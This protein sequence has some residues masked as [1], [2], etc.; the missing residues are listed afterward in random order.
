MKFTCSR[1]ELYEALQSVTRAVSGR[2]TDLEL[3]IRRPVPALT[4]EQ[5]G[6]ITVPAKTLSEIVSALPPKAELTIEV[7]EKNT[8]V[9][10]CAKSRYKILGLSADEFPELPRVSQDHAFE[11]T[12]ADLH[13]MIRSVILAAGEDNTRPILTSVEVK[14]EGDRLKM[15]ATDTHRLAVRTCAV[16]A[17]ADQAAGVCLI[18]ASSLGEVLRV[19]DSDGAE[20]VRVEFDKNQVQFNVNGILVVSRLIDGTYPQYER[21]IPTTH[22]RQWTFNVGELQQAVKRAA[23]VAKEN[24]NRV[25]LTIEGESLTV[26]AQAGDLGQAYEE[27][28]IEREGDP[29][30]VVFNCKY[31]LDLCGLKEADHLTMFL[32]EPLAPVVVRPVHGDGYLM[33]IMPM[34]MT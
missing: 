8:A 6:R 29:S 3:G 26:T 4:I 10:R 32:T 11:V 9:V 23:I 1:N 27:F 17:P 15:A 28:A 30:S 34:Q 33:V 16:N 14:V 25:V 2:S 21:V 12:H 24:S 7:D 22:T 31:L 19:L 13:R 20:A 5:A 18:P